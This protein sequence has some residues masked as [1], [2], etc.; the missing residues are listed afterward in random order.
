MCLNADAQ[1]LTG[2]IRLYE[3]A[4][5]HVQRQYVTYEKELCP[6]EELSTQSVGG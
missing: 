6:G 2:A 5:M 4:G 1:D 3:K